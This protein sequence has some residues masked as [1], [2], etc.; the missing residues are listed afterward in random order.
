MIFALLLVLL[1]VSAIYLLKIDNQFVFDD[2]VFIENCPRHSSPANIPNFFVT[3]HFRL[4]RPI[5]SIVYTVTRALFGIDPVA[6]NIAG[7]LFH[8]AMVAVFFFLCLRLLHS[9]RAATLAALFFGLHPLA[10]ANVTFMTASFDVPGLA[11][12]FSSLLPYLTW[13]RTGKRESLSISLLLLLLGLLASEQCA[14]VPL[15]MILLLFYRNLGFPLVKRR[16]A[17]AVSASF[18]ILIAYLILRSIVVV[19]FS[20]VNSYSA[21]GIYPTLLTMSVVFW[22]Y[23]RLSF[24]PTGLA[25]DHS[26]T[27]IEHLSPAPII[28]ALGIIAL[29][30]LFFVSR[31]KAPVLFLALGW[32]FI[33]LSPVSNIIPIQTFFAERYGYSSLMGIAMLCGFA[34]DR[35]LA[36]QTTSLRR[37][38]VY[39]A[40][41]LIF[42][43]MLIQTVD[44]IRVWH[45]PFSLWTDNL[46]KYPNNT[47]ANHN[48]GV[49][50]NENGRSQEAIPYFLKVI[51]VD[52]KHSESYRMLGK[53]Y[54]KL[55]DLEKAKKYYWLAVEKFEQRLKETPGHPRTL[56]RLTE[57][58]A[59]LGD[60]HSALKYADQLLSDDPDNAIALNAASFI[61]A[62]IGRCDLA[63]PMFEH[64][65]AVDETGE[66][67]DG[68]KANL[69]RCREQPLLKN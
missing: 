31:K 36:I 46:I 6:H 14:V 10:A 37:G 66:F 30:V 11:I 55:G 5:R 61:F 1:S 48:M 25:A 38:L 15:L 8:D 43:C 40:L 50:L 59:L 19:G 33:N 57:L 27:I 21:G 28:G 24:F 69:K 42:G 64:L 63:I 2:K 22:K 68:A 49:A 52:P 3:D 54:E 39:G 13:L 32:F 35:L 12:G 65:I 47:T 67:A 7:I 58:Y 29:V 44:R 45:D 4:Y 60:R 17:Y 51:E 56:E 18:A 20:R 23:V 62:S 9:L 16:I 53:T 26:V 41:G 34:V